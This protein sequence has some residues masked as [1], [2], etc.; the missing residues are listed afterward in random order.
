[1]TS[2]EAAPRNSPAALP[3]AGAE[4]ELY[5]TDLLANGQAVGRAG[6]MAVFCFGP[7]P[8][9]TALVRVTSVKRRY[10]VATL[11]RVLTA[12]PDRCQPFCP[13]F[14]D[15]GGCQV[16]HLNYPAQLAWKREL[17]R[18]TLARIGGFAGVEVQP[19]VGMTV[20][21][22][23]R[24]KMSLVVEHRSTPPAIGFYKQRSHDVVAIDACPIV[25]TQ[26]SDYI[27]QLNA[28]RA[29]GEIA[30]ALAPARHLVAR[31]S[32]TAG[33]AV[34]TITTTS[35][36]DAVERAAPA[37]RARLPALAGLINSFDLSSANAIVGRRRRVVSGTGD[38][39][40][41]IAGL[42][43][44]ISPDSFFQINVEIVARIFAYIRP[45]IVGP[46]RVVDL[47]CG[48]GT[49]AL[50]FA[51]CGCDVFGVEESAQA[52]AEARANAECNG[53]AET[54][55]LHQGRVENV[56]RAPQGREVLE[57]AEIAFLDPPRKGSDE[58]TLG[59]L[60]AARVPNVWYLS[61]DPAT[62]ARDL[63]FLAAK[64]YRL[65]VVQPF[66]MFP[67]TGHVETLVMLQYAI[68]AV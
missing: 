68:H 22:N 4:L 64:G 60:V 63:K 37:L 34:L 35:A 10:A 53:L 41:V 14:G 3:R 59:A 2:R 38:V 58:T 62:L 47:Y 45:H 20:P 54:V 5:F 25:A 13:V 43:Y 28:A 31:A 21:R 29:V 23:Y 66:D 8:R 1:M 17:V 36:S 6:G 42:H 32:S 27:A 15:C 48:V 65:G 19:T 26:L 61:C 51:R 40:E 46:Q 39:E 12:S 52:I 50:F 56:L 49:F 9:E 33:Q 11:K 7:L 30:A 44:R 18:N 55:R 57:R 67:Q 16:Q 24:N